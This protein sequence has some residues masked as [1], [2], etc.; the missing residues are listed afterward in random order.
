MVCC[1][2]LLSGKPSFFLQEDL[3][4]RAARKLK[5]YAEDHEAEQPS[6]RRRATADTRDR[7]GKRYSKAPEAQVLAPKVDGA[8][9]RISIWQGG[10]LSKKD[11]NAFIR[12]V[13]RNILT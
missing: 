11:A 13:S 12:A 1:G 5:S 7:T 10:V 2:Y 4:P 6:K 8:A 3:A 9:A